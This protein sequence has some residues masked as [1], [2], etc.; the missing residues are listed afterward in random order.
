MIIRTPRVDWAGQRHRDVEGW[1][2]G[3]SILIILLMSCYSP[4]R[5]ATL[6]CAFQSSSVAVPSR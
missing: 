1:D 3:Y 2:V 4:V 5:D 6:R